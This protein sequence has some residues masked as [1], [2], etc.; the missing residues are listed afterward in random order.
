MVLAVGFNDRVPASTMDTGGVSVRAFDPLRAIAKAAIP[1]VCVLDAYGGRLY[2]M[3]AVPSGS[4]L[5][6]VERYLAEIIAPELSDIAY[7]VTAP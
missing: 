2:A 1:Y 5:N 6:P 3:L 7:I 4:H